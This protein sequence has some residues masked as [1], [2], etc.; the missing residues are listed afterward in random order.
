MKKQAWAA[1]IGILVIV[2]VA[3]YFGLKAQAKYQQAQLAQQQANNNFDLQTK[4]ASQAKTFFNDNG[5]KSG[6]EYNFSYE[7]HFDSQLN[8][9]FIQV[10]S[11]M[12][13]NDSLIVDLYDALGGEHY[14]SYIG[15]S[16]CGTPLLGG[17]NATKCELD[18]GNIWFDGNDTRN[19]AD[20]H[21]GFGGL[22]HGGVGDE[23]TFNDFMAHLQPFM[24]N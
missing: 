22:L 15:H 11:Y 18:S 12:P 16:D 23:N 21:V 4:C 9:C 13:S 14:A 3:A 10:S 17:S 5:Y 20:Y 7:D 1:V 6:T 19:P 8:K 24:S 2:G